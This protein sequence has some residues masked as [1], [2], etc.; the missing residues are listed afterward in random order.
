MNTNIRQVFK[1]SDIRLTLW[2]LKCLTECMLVLAFAPA[3]ILAA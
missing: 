2:T 3:L 1:G